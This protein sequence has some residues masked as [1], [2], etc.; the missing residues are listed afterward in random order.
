MSAKK[1]VCNLAKIECQMCTNPNGT[2][3]VTSN[4]IKLQ[5]KLWATEKDKE[6]TNLMFQ[7]TCKASPQQSVPC[8]AVM[9]TGQ[10]QGLGDI[11]VQGS[12]PL[13]ES[14]TIMCNYGGAIIKIKDDLQKSQPSSLLPTAVDGITPDVPVS[15][16]L[17]TSSLEND[18]YNDVASADD[19]GPFV[20]E[21]GLNKENLINVTTSS[22]KF[23]FSLKSNETHK[24]QTITAKKL[25]N[26][27]IQWFCPQADNYLKLIKA[28]D[29]LPT[30]NE[31]KHFT[32][33]EI[34]KFSEI[35]RW[36]FNYRSGGS[37]DWKLSAKGADGYILVEIN[38]FPYWA[39]A[40][41]QIPF[42]IDVFTDYLEDGYT[43][44]Q[45]IKKTILTGQKYGDG[46]I[47][48]GKSDFS[49]EY[50]NHIILRSCLWAKKRYSV[51]VTSEMMKFSTRKIYTLKKNSFD[52]NQLGEKLTKEQVKKYFNNE[53]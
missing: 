19:D 10:W 4:M 41:G 43:K 17:I 52:E 53:N 51:S 14:S 31:L 38:G 40:I 13:L 9:Q 2:L 48:G 39:D 35:E 36:N 20:S 12:K 32:W 1:Y 6:K 21:K 28:N 29:Q 15:L 25:Y 49:N 33:K 16:N 44:E 45:A 24:A 11:S 8:I 18:D 46:K 26:K 27:K 42:S 34:V 7:G 3:M 50:D 47:F 23:L 5:G 30:F 37:G 22:G